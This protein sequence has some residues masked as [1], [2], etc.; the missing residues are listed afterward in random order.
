M[1]EYMPEK[2]PLTWSAA[3]WLIGLV[4]ACSGGLLNWYAKVK[5][6]VTRPFNF[7]ELIGEVFTSGFVGMGV[8]MALDAL[9]Q[10]LGLC[11]AAAGVTGHMATRFLFTIEQVIEHHIE[12]LK[13]DGDEKSR[14]EKQNG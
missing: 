6:G 8:F 14:K 7:I 5:A 9:G 1:K 12:R 10:P 11:A 2:D 13:L 4:M 3:T